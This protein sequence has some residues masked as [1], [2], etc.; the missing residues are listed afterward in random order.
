[1]PV[2]GV[3]DHDDVGLE[4]FHVGIV[5]VP[6]AHHSGG[7]VLHHYI[8][9][10]DQ[11]TEHIPSARVGHI[12]GDGAFAAVDQVVS[13]GTVPP[14]VAQVVLR[15]GAGIASGAGH[16]GAAWPFNLDH[17]RAQVGQQAARV[18]QGKYVG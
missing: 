9:D 11:V 17:L 3:G 12:Q 14:V 2:A 10:L 7:E 15:E 13:G 16:I 6:T 8:A 18:R 4:L 5:E 1:M